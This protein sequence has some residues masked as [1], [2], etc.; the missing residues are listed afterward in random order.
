MYLTLL[1]HTGMRVDAIVLAVG[2]D[3]MRVV[4]ND[5]T[6]TIE[7]RLKNKRWMTES[8]DT[9]EL[10]SMIPNDRMDMAGLYYH[11]H[12]RGAHAA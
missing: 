10:E 9:V 5:R 1:Y 11:M 12:H 6:D 3:R 7:L 8:G 4:V 2:R